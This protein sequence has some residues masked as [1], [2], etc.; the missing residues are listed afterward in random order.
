[1]SKANG[2]Y[3]S[4]TSLTTLSAAFFILLGWRLSTIQRL[5]P[6]LVF[7]ERADAMLYSSES[8]SRLT[9]IVSLRCWNSRRRRSLSWWSRRAW[10]LVCEIFYNRFRSRRRIKSY[11]RENSTMRQFE[12]SSP[13]IA[14]TRASTVRGK[15]LAFFS[16]VIGSYAKVKRDQDLPSTITIQVS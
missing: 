4:L 1:M 15:F 2:L 7:K 14:A 10:W 12:I 13:N 8:R 9:K 11:W 6:F 16:F 3:T 5:Y